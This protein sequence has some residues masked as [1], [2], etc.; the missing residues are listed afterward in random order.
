MELRSRGWSISAAGRT[1]GVSRTTAANWARGHKTYRD[2]E[3]VGLVEPLDRLAV[4]QPLRDLIG[5]LLGQRWSP[6]QIARHLRAHQHHDQL[7]PRF[8][9]PMLSI[10]QWPFAPDYRS[11]AGHWEGDLIVGRARGSAIGTLV[12][13][14]TCTI[15]LVHMPAS[16]A[17]TLHAAVIARMG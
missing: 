8:E 17:D 13:R 2:G 10:H 11:E 6:G 9:Q 12:E 3:V 7:R 1:V 16:D 4:S 15:G 5:E 14:Q